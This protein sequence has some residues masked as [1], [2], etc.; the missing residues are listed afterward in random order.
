MLAG[1]FSCEI[2]KYGKNLIAIFEEF[3]A[4]IRK[5]LILEGGLGTGLPF[6]EVYTLS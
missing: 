4:T 6:C 1:W 5:I 3:F 2:A